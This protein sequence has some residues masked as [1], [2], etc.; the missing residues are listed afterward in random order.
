MISMLI[1]I[2]AITICLTLALLGISAENPI[3]EW[4]A[5]MGNSNAAIHFQRL[6]ESNAGTKMVKCIV[7]STNEE[8]HQKNLT[9]EMKMAVLNKYCTELKGI[10]QKCTDDLLIFFAT[11]IDENNLE[12]AKT[13]VTE[14][15]SNVL[16]M[17]CQNRV[18]KFVEFLPPR[19]PECRTP[20][21]NMLVQCP[22]NIIGNDKHVSLLDLNCS[23]IQAL[24]KCFRESLAPCKQLET[25]LAH[26]FSDALLAP[27]V[28]ARQ[29][30]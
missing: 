9:T 23:Q 7:N 1:I 12:K 5:A 13:C 4:C 18:E 17:I 11:C 29:C 22:R 15:I 27:L 21:Y 3:Q 2:K 28:R 8:F 24:K 26:S 19:H 25:S 30:Q 10:F 20:F 14:S 6:N 16:D